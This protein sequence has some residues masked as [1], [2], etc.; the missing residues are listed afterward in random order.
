MNLV[1]GKETG[2]LKP[3]WCCGGVWKVGR[4]WHCLVGVPSPGR[5]AVPLSCLAHHCIWGL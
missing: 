3:T 2:V 5:L 1:V 4:A